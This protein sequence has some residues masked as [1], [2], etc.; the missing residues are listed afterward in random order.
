M[1]QLANWHP[2]DHWT[3]ITTIDMHTG[4]EPLRIIIDGLPPI[5]GRTVLEKR[6]YFREHY[7]HLRRGLM[8][9]P[10]GHADMYGAVI[11]P[12]ADADFDV[13]FL[14]NEGYSTMC[15]HA[16]IALTKLVVDLFTKTEISINVP[17]GRIHAKATVSNG[18][19]VETSFRNVPSFVHL[20]DQ[21]VHV[22]G[23]GSVRFD[24]A[25]GG[26]FYAIVSADEVGLELVPRNLN[27]LIDYGRRIKDAVASQFSIVH[28]AEPELSFLYGTI[29]TGPPENVARHSRNVCIFADGEVDR[30]PTGSGV[31]ARAALHFAKGEL[32]LNE[33]VTIES[34]VG[35]TMD[36]KLVE[37]AVFGPYDA[38][39]PEVSGTASITGRH[40]FYFDPED[41]FQTGF[42]LR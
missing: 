39:I 35:S 13:F 23:I 5:E 30:S 42:I 7:D 12:S 37:V 11:T 41:P 38:V 6:R 9:E 1:N 19:V 34:I 26:A 15:G 33:R 28:P 4:G 21:Q 32:R 14:N 29:F 16:I 10:R 2:P 31:S 25:Y 24:V 36:V 3:R 8:W 18:R 40:E 27:R 17:A 20:R 22:D